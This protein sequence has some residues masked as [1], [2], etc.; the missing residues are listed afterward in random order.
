[1]SKEEKDIQIQHLE[2]TPSLPSSG[3]VEFDDFSDI[4][5]KKVRLGDLLDSSSAPT[6][7]QEA[8]VGW[9]K[10]N[11]SNGHE[12]GDGKTEHR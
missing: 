5:E 10:S 9:L 11:T 1:M 7:G 2:H 12:V 4:D 8:E 6:S 3:E